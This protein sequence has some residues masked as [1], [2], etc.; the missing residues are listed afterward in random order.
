MGIAGRAVTDTPHFIRWNRFKYGTFSWMGQAPQY[1]QFGEPGIT[2]RRFVD[3]W[4]T[5]TVGDNT[6][7]DTLLYY[8]ASGGLTGILNTYPYG[9]IERDGRVLDGPGNVSITLHPQAEPRVKQELIAEAQRRWP[10]IDCN[11][12]VQYCLGASGVTTTTVGALIDGNRRIARLS[13]RNK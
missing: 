4:A 2:Y 10:K 12:E 13:A 5:S 1:D 3:D 11:T 7:I 8:D 6:I 9:A